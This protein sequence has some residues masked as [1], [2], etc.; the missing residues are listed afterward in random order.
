MAEDVQSDLPAGQT[1]SHYRV[2]RRIGAGA[3]GVVYRARDESLDRDVALKFLA[4]GA[5]S[6]AVSKSRFIREAKAASA[7]DHPNVATV[8]EIGQWRDQDFIAM[9]FYDGE[10]LKERLERGTMPPDDVVGLVGQIAAGLAAAHA[11]GIVHRDLKPANIAI[12]S[13]GT[14]KILDF[15]LAKVTSARQETGIQVTQPGTTLGTVAYMAPEQVRAEEADTRSDVWALGV[16]AYEMLTGR[17]PFTGDDTFT[18]MQAIV[19]ETPTSVARLRPDAPPALAQLVHAALEKDRSKRSITSTA[20]VQAAAAIHDRATADRTRAPAGWARSPLG[21][22]IA[23]IAL[24]ALSLGAFAWWRQHTRLQW[25]RDIAP[26]EIRKLADDEQFMEAFDAAVRAEAIIPQHP[27]LAELWPIISRAASIEST[28]PGADVVYRKYGDRDGEWRPLGRTPVTKVKFPRGAFEL[29]VALPGYTDVQDIGLPVFD[30]RASYTLER[31]QDVPDGMVRASAGGEPFQIF[32]PGLDHLPPVTLD[33]YWLD[34]HEVTNA[35]FKRFVDA[36][37]YRQAQLWPASCVEDGRAISREEALRRF[38]DGTGRPGPSTWESGSYPAGQDDY[39][40]TGVSWYEAAAYAAFVG[41]QLPTVFHWSMVA[42]QTM[43]GAVVPASNFSGKGPQ[44]VGRSGA[45]NRFGAVDMGGNAKEWVSNSAG[46]GKRYILGGAWDEP[47]YM[48]TDGDAR[49]PMTREATFGFRC[50]KLVGPTHI[51]GEIAGE[52]AYPFRDYAAERPVSDEIFTQYLNFYRYDRLDLAARVERVDDSRAEW[53][54]EKVSF[55]AAYGGE[56]IVAY[57]FLPKQGAP[58][59]QTVVYFPGAGAIANRTSEPIG[60][61]FFDFLL[62]SGRSVVFP[63]YKGTYERG[64]GI[65]SDYPNMSANWRDHM[66][67]IAKDLG[68]TIDYL[69]SRPDIAADRLGYMGSSWGGAMGA[70]LPAI[71]PRLKASV[72]RVGGFYQQRSLP[73]VDAFNF[74]PRVKIPTLMLSGRYDFFYPTQASQEPMFALLGAP[75][76]DKKRIVY[77]TGHT[78]PRNEMIKETLDWFDKYLGPTQ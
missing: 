7:L 42:D 68:R 12:T 64:G 72:L 60:T 54:L 33:D 46:E 75:A 62:K 13:Q 29:E 26:L 69:S 24:I 71:E 8:Y 1:V 30:V 17:L 40:V 65:I 58:P 61:Q 73:E 23:A 9:A 43:S 22:A 49:S 55:S 4:A 48:F 63:V 39:P 16:I 31:P 11:K 32:Y 36:G 47:V 37:G 66:V 10:T 21:R 70:W 53:R 6:D 35:E 45:W 44:P 74:T 34:R 59:Y 50:M 41:K 2:V 51:A 56:R 18:I 77:D 67:M 14:A 78:I 38:V 76:N 20:F 25:A 27:G 15:G 52:I 5:A 57:V 28:P 3:M 19:A